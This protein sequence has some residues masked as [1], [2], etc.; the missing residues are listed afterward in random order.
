MKVLSPN[1]LPR[2]LFGIQ[3][4]RKYFAMGKVSWEEVYRRN[5]RER[6]KKEKHPLDILKELDTLISKGYERVPEEDLVRL[7]WYG[8]YHDKPRTGTFL[9]RIKVPAGRLTPDQLLT[10]GELAKKLNN[11]AELTTRQDIQLHYIKLEDLP[12]VIFELKTVGLFRPG[13]CGDTVRNITSCPVAGV[14]KDEIFE[15][16][17]PIKRLSEFFSDP[18]H[19]E[20]FD[21]PRKFKIT[22][23]ACPYH[24]N[25]PELHDLA[26][27]GMLKGGKEGFAVWVGGGLSSTPRIARPLGIFVEPDKV[28]EVAKAV[29]DIWKEDPENR[30]S[31]VRARIKYFIDRIGVESFKKLLLERLSFEPEFLEEEPKPIKRDF[32]E[33]I[34][35]QKQRGLYYITVPVQAGRVKGDQLLKIG[36]IAKEEDLGIRISQRQNLILT[37]VQ[38]DKIEYITKKLKDIGFPLDVSRTRCLS[39]ACTSDPFCNYSIGSAKETLIEILNY[40]EERLGDLGNILIGSDGCPHACAHHWL[41]DIG[42]QATHI[43]HPDGSVESG[44]NIILRGS[45]GKDAGIGK[46]I[47]KKVTVEKAKK[48]LENLIKAFKKSSAANFT[49]FVRSL[50]DEELL[51]I[52][53]GEEEVSKTEEKG[54]RI[55]MMGPLSGLTGGLSELWVE[56]KTLRELID[57]LDQDYPG[58][59]KKILN[60]KGEVKSVINVFVNEEDVKYLKGLDTELKEGDEV[61][62]ILALAG[63]AL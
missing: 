37:H 20:Y 50:D 34:R 44:L 11:Y 38:E 18:N 42:L 40:L 24:C 55:R 15:V 21:L 16:E 51:R 23:S 8:L 26:F 28:L 58:F 48:Y 62:F 56:A 9:L 19:R 3:F 60:E 7:Q 6:L 39:I 5:P 59:K 13:P 63:G 49:E 32:H 10:I 4:A 47:V 1:L 27:V 30:K 43:R 33:G 52:M 17:E 45:Y 36:E 22:L 31:F 2:F 41:N 61:Q 46:I 14:D 35:E 12:E 25:H 53:K 54:V 29:V 57:K